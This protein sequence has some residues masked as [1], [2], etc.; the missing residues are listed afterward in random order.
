LAGIDGY[1]IRPWAIVKKWVVNAAFNGGNSGGPLIHIETGNR[2][3]W[4]KSAAAPPRRRRLIPALSCRSCLPDAPFAELVR[5][6]RKSIADEMREQHRRR[7]P[8][9]K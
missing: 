7:V 4:K 5:L 8:G 9:D 6:S 1:Q 3:R 2:A